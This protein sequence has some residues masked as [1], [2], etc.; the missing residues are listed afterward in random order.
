MSDICM[1]TSYFWT[2]SLSSA[3]VPPFTRGDRGSAS[4]HAGMGLEEFLGARLPPVASW[5]SGGPNY[6]IETNNRKINRISKS[7]N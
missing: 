5:G 6:Q 3:L 1:S 2:L 4:H 7:G